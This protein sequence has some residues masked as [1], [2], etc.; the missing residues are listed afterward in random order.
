MREREFRKHLSITLS[1]IVNNFLKMAYAIQEFL[2]FINFQLTSRLN[3]YF[4]N[5]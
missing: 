3:N 2:Y 5:S 1:I 4:H